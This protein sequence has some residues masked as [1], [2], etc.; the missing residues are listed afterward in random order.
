MKYSVNYVSSQV[1]IATVTV[2][3]G[4]C[5]TAVAFISA[6]TAVTVAITLLMQTPAFS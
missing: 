2:V 3:Q 4:L 5:L 6:I 1:Y